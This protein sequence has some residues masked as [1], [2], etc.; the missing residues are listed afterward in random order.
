MKRAERQQQPSASR[1]SAPRAGACRPALHAR[2]GGEHDERGDED[3]AAQ[4]QEPMLA[5]WGRCRKVGASL[6]RYGRRR[7]APSVF[8][9]RR[10]SAAATFSSRC[11]T[12]DVPGITSIDRRTRQQPRER[13]LVHRGAVAPRHAIQRTALLELAGGQREP[14]DEG[15]TLPLAVLHLRLPFPVAHVVPILDRDDGQRP[16]RRLDL[17]GGHLREAE[18]PA[19]APAR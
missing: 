19:P 7:P 14:G 9:G 13:H 11:P 18:P 15:E 5:P 8:L 4:H 16:P 3:D 10:I 6:Q 2:R 1:S 17:R 12:E